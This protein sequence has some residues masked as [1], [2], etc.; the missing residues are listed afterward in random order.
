MY[1]WIFYKFAALKLSHDEAGQN[2]DLPFGTIFA[3]LMCAM[4]TG[5]LFFTCHCSLAPAARILPSPTL[6]TTTLAAARM[7]LALPVL[8]HDEPLTFWCFCAFE[9]CCGIYF[10]S[11]AHLKASFVAD[12]ERANTY[13]ILRIPLDAFVVVCLMLTRDGKSR[14]PR[15]RRGS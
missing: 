4:M 5:S 11:T 3:G 15:S 6:L 9:V 10:P 14:A 12:R 1:L 13:G 7:C 2:T 8:V